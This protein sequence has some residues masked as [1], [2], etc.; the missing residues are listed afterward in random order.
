MTSQSTGYNKF[1]SKHEQVTSLITWLANIKIFTSPHSETNSRCHSL[2]RK[3]CLA[4]RKNTL[5]DV[6][7]II[8]A[9]CVAILSKSWTKN[10]STQ[11][12]VEISTVIQQKTTQHRCRSQLSC[13]RHHSSSN[14]KRWRHNQQGAI[15]SCPST[16][17]WRH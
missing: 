5:Y 14:M 17:K 9:I 12:Q 3:L 1:L 6:W 13:M 7:E 16:N 2:K 15:H 4:I 8:R 11:L 10:N